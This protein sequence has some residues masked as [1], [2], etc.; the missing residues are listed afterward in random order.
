MEDI[1]K[2]EVCGRIAQV[3]TEVAGPRGKSSFAKQLG[4][5]PSTYDY[6]ESTRIP[7][8]TVLVRI[9]DVA[10][11]DLR[12]LLTGRGG[13]SPAGAGHPVVRRAAEL[14]DGCPSAAQP[15]A[16]FL[17]LLEGTMAFPAGAAGEHTGQT[18]DAERPDFAKVSPAKQ[19]ARPAEGAAAIADG[20]QPPGKQAARDKKAEGQVQSGL[21]AP[22]SAGG[23]IPAGTTGN[24]RDV[25]ADME[26]GETGA[27]ALQQEGAWIPILGR[28]AAG[29][30]QFWADAESAE[31]VLTLRQIVARRADRS[32]ARVSAAQTAELGGPTEA[33]AIVTLPDPQG[34]DVSEF[35]VAGALRDRFA[36]AFALRVD[37]S[38]MA[39]DIRHGDLVILSPSAPA[40]DGRPAVVQLTGQIGVT[41]KLYRREAQTVHLVPLE[42]SLSPVSVPAEQVTWALRVL[43]RVRP[44]D[45]SAG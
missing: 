17:E 1:R 11:V 44:Q 2:Q 35:V 24:G 5:S 19:A 15:L 26:S 23:A 3:R 29:L 32:A 21:A 9:A 6:Y 13:S 8:A 12:W 22:R 31:E 43:A 14:L 20:G 45:V 25:S 16:A 34:E 40:V 41:C 36:D 37:G 39:P 27:E 38:S 42:E 7:P 10:G 4:I 33:G 18:K 28:T 30:P